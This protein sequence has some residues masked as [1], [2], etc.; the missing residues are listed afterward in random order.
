MNRSVPTTVAWTTPAAWSPARRPMA[1]PWAACS[2]AWGEA[3]GQQGPGGV[4]ERE[5]PVVV[6]L[7]QLLGGLF[8]GGQVSVEASQVAQPQQVGTAQAA[9]PQRLAQLGQLAG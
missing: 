8:G 4:G 1:R 6:E 7:A 2:S 9:A 5:L 3:A